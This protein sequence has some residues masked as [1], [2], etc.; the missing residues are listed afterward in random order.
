MRNF[1]GPVPRTNDRFRQCQYFLRIHADITLSGVFLG[2]EAQRDLRSGRQQAV[3]QFN[4][5]VNDRFGT[6]RAAGM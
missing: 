4:D 5:T 2:L 1:R 3:E 6:R